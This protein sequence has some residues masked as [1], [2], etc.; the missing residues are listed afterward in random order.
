MEQII[1]DIY[2]K[3]RPMHVI[4]E[5]GVKKFSF[6]SVKT[7]ND[8]T[9]T[10]PTY[11]FN[12]NVEIV[13][14]AHVPLED[15][16][17]DEQGNVQTATYFM[18]AL[19]LGNFEENQR[20]AYTIGFNHTQL[21]DGYVEPEKKPIPPEREQRLKVLVQSDKDQPAP[22][23]AAWPT[24]EIDYRSVEDVE[25]WRKW[26][27]TYVAFPDGPKLYTAHDDEWVHE[28]MGKRA[29]K[30]LKAN[31]DVVIAGTFIKEDVTYGRPLMAAKNFLWYGV[32]MDNL[33][34]DD[35][36][37]NTNIPLHERAALPNGRLS[38]SERYIT[39]PLAKLV[40]QTT[41]LKASLNKIKT[42]KEQK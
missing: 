38:V 32:R 36:L 33:I 18:D 22:D 17:R 5:D 8:L 19:A 20:P 11:P 14:E 37:Y 27:S 42:N 7:W 25:E 15:E 30:L 13:A 29:D 21:S 39:V 23:M 40:S 9:V 4:V 35:E 3:P 16:P 24:T 1:Y 31:H 41:R 12:A 28:F 34:S 26:L 10:G 6:A 2:P